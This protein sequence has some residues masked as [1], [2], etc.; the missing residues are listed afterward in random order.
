[1][2]LIK[3]IYLINVWGDIHYMKYSTTLRVGIDGKCVT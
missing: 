2:F 1:M 3:Y